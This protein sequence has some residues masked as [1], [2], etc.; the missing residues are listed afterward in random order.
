M[1]S[2]PNQKL[3]PKIEVVYRSKGRSHENE[4]RLFSNAKMNVT[5]RAEK[6]YEM[7]SFVTLLCLFSELLP[8]KYSKECI[9]CNSVL[10]SARTESIRANYIYASTSS[11]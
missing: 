1:K 5:N 3:S 7:G 10:T 4:F 6:I 8:I 2:F 11:Y 9:F